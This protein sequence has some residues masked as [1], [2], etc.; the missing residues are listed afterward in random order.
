MSSYHRLISKKGKLKTEIEDEN[1]LELDI[2]TTL[3][4]AE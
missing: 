1:K 3:Q 4:K 2:Q